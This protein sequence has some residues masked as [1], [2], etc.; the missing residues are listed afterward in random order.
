MK[1][2]LVFVGVIILVFGA[3]STGS[4]LSLVDGNANLVYD[5]NT[6]KYWYR[7]LSD[8]R[9]M[10]FAEQLE[11]IDAM[12][13][14]YQALF[15]DWHVAS[16]QEMQVLWSYGANE[17][18]ANFLPSSTQLA[19]NLPSNNMWQGRYGEVK[20]TCPDFF[21][22]FVDPEPYHETADI[23]WKGDTVSTFF[24]PILVTD[25]S[26]FAYDSWVDYGYGV[27]VV[28][29]AHPPEGNGSETPDAVPEPASLILVGIGLLML[30]VIRRNL[31]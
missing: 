1:K 16:E 13:G 15:N 24:R 22:W 2:F 19:I 28:T 5:E 14:A 9:N 21:C 26:G 12:N 30:A 27:W 20:W 10:N 11:T 3:I 6:N 29:D 7:D 4:A 18:M 25:M 17:I 8:F 23:Y 31:L